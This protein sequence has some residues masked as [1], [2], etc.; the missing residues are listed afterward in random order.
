MK[1]AI[2]SMTLVTLI[3]GGMV[4]LDNFYARKNHLKLVAIRLDQQILYDKLDRE[5]CNYRRLEQQ[6]GDNCKDGDDR[7][8][9]ECDETKT[10]IERVRKKIDAIPDEVEKMY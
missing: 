6:Y 1:I 5:K 7:A 2:A 10:E 9:Q 3:A 8:K 4:G